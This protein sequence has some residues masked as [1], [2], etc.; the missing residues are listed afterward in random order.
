MLKKILLI[1]FYFLQLFVVVPTIL[2][3]ANGFKLDTALNKELERN[4]QLIIVELVNSDK[5]WEELFS[6]TFK[7]HKKDGVVCNIKCPVILQWSSWSCHCS[8]S[9]GHK[10]NNIFGVGNLY[11]SQG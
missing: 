5:N 9:Q 8:Q 6:S 11:L 1:L 3:D 7:T 2:R 4:F 10:T